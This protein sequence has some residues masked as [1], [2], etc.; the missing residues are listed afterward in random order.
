MTWG[1]FTWLS[2]PKKEEKNTDRSAGQIGWV[3]KTRLPTGGARAA[4]PRTSAGTIGGGQVE[5]LA[6]LPPTIG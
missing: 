1:I 6:L 2:P 3:K 5:R 4:E